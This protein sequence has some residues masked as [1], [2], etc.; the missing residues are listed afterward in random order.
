MC[1]ALNSYFVSVF[2]KDTNVDPIPC[3]DA[4]NSQVINDCEISPQIVA[5]FID[6]LKCTNS[7]DPNGYSN[8]F[9]K[10]FKNEL[11][12]PLSK[13]FNYSLNTGNVPCDWRKAN[14]MPIFKKGQKSSPSNY[15]PVSLTS[16]I[17]KLFERILQNKIVDHLEKNSLLKNSQHGF[18]GK[19]SCTSNL[20]AFLEY[21]T[22]NIDNGDPVDV[23]YYDFSKA[24]DKVSINK[25]MQ[26]VH[27]YGI[28]GKLYNWIKEWLTN[29]RQRTV[30]G[31]E[32]SDHADVESGVPQGSV[33]G[34]LLFI[35]Y[36]DDID[37]CAENIDLILK[38]ADD[39]KTVNRAT[40]ISDRERLQECI[41]R[42][43]NWSILWSMSF[44]ISKCKVIH[45]GH[46]NVNHDYTMNGDIIAKA[47]KER[48]IGVDV[49]RSLKP[50]DHCSRAAGTAF[51]ILYQLLRSFHYRDKK[52]FVQLYKTYVRPHLEFAAPVWSPWLK[53]DILALEKVQEK[54]VKNITCLNGKT[55]KE[56]LA[57]IN[58]MSLE[59]RR[60]YLEL[61]ETYKII[62]GHTKVNRESLFELVSDN[63]RRTTRSTDCPINI[64]IKRCNLDIRLNFYTMRIGNQ[65]NSLPID[66]KMSGTLGSFKMQLHKHMMETYLDV[67]NGVRSTQ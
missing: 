17:C 37:N 49:S 31:G 35:I 15:R 61:V 29:R 53:K 16:V 2:S 40:T 13:I 8:R 36:I 25:L 52:I 64:I 22:S 27:A 47:D 44:N 55:Y 30:I 20:L 9:L 63:P 45:F 4:N 34:P 5:K 1:E 46:N 23:I 57:E 14:V 62:R 33:L 58:M 48:D 38:F 67:E 32:C 60:T 56:K 12:F 6:K 42:M 26:K 19:L 65:W 3:P 50:S 66:I 7:K 28:R 43:Y 21:T 41:N 51:G 10:D 39:T 54:F 59:T 11:K 24:F 18:R